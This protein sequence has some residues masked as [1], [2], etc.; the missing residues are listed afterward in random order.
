MTTGKVKFP[1]TLLQR[2]FMMLPVSNQDVVTMSCAGTK[3]CIL[4]VLCIDS[5]HINISLLLLF[6]ISSY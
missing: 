6:L 4:L 3:L 2:K 5:I 1:D